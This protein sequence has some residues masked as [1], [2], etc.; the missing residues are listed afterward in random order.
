MSHN[1]L[2]PRTIAAC[3]MLPTE[4]ASSVGVLH[5]TT[6]RFCLGVSSSASGVT[7]LGSGVRRTMVASTVSLGG[8]FAGV[9]G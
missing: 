1:D 9:P 7:P 6:K 4:M 3:S 2:Q 5:S 8:A